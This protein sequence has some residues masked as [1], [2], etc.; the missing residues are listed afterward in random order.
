MTGCS[1]RYLTSES[2]CTSGGYNWGTLVWRTGRCSSDQDKYET[3]ATCVAASKSWENDDWS[4]SCLS[5][6]SEENASLYNNDKNSC[7]PEWQSETV[8]YDNVS[9]SMCTTAETGNR[10]S[11]WDWNHQENNFAQT[12][13]DT[14]SSYSDLDGK[15]LVNRMECLKTSDSSSSQGGWTEEYSALAKV[16]KSKKTL[17]LIS[18]ETEKAINLWFV[19]DKPFYSS[20]DTSQSLYLLSGLKTGTICVDTSIKEES[21]C[22]AGSWSER[23]CVLDYASQSECQEA[24]LVWQAVYPYNIMSNFEIYNLA[25]SGTENFLFADGLDF[26]NNQYKF[27]TIDIVKKSLSLK[28]GLTGTL[29]TIVIL[30]K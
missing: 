23:Q 1:H 17:E 21:A 20:Y 26:S 7:I 6:D 14:R 28:Q 12:A 5:S 9:G 19:E 4:G 29:K 30:P 25:E 22:T 13:S 15:F 16:N 2:S 3:E 18:L 8:W 27:G 10:D 11:W 24:G